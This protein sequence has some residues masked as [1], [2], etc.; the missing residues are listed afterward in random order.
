MDKALVAYS[1][2]EVVTGEIALTVAE[3]LTR[4]GLAADLRPYNRARPAAE[5]TA[6]VL[7]TASGPTGV[8]AAVDYISANR[9]DLDP[10][11]TRVFTWDPHPHPAEDAELAGLLSE[12]GLPQPVLLPAPDRRWCP[13]TLSWHGSSHTDWWDRLCWQEIR[14][15]AQGL[16]DDLQQQLALA[17]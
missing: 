9:T 4:S 15:W 16:A 7:G 17:G 10:A 1:T 13:G 8:R 5:Y 12:L 14:V 3:Q 11:R 2:N 6:V